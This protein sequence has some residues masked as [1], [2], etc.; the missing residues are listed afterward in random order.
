MLKG[1]SGKKLDIPPFL[2]PRQGVVIYDADGSITACN[3][4]AQEILGLTLAKLQDSSA[5]FLWQTI[6]SDGMLLRPEVSPAMETLRTGESYQ[7]VLT[8]FYRS[9]GEVTWLSVDTEPWLNA[10]VGSPRSV[11]ATFREVPAPQ[12]ALPARTPLSDLTIKSAFQAILQNTSNIIFFKDIQGR[13]VTLSQTAADFLGMGVSEAI[14]KTDHDL[15]CADVLQKIQQD[16]A[17]VMKTGESVAFEEQILYAG[18]VRTLLT[19]KIPWRDQSGHLC[20][21]LGLCR[22]ITDLKQAEQEDRQSRQRL[23]KVLDSLHSIVGLLTPEGVLVEVSQLAL[24]AATLEADEVIGKP[25]P[26]AYWWSYSPEIQAQLWAAVHQAASG[27]MVRYDVL[28]RLSEAQF[29]TIDFSI[30]PLLNESREVEYLVL[31]GLDITYRQETEKTL[32]QNQDVIQSQLSEIESIYQTAPI[33]MAVLDTELRFV[34]INQ[35]LA[36]IN[37]LSVE[38]HI[39]RS[40][41]ELLPALADEAEPQLRQILQT[42]KPVLN[43]EISGET[44]AQPDTQRTWVESWYPQ[45]GQDAQPVGIHIVCEEITERRQ[46]DLA[47]R[48]SETRFRLLTELLPQI[49][50]TATAQG[51]IDYYSEQWREYVGSALKSELGWELHHFIHPEDQA[52][53]AAQWLRSVEEGRFYQIEHRI[54]RVDGEYR[55]YLS[56]AMPNLSDSGEVLKWYGT[57]IDIHERKQTLEALDWALSREKLARAESERANRTKDEFLAVLSH[58]LRSPLNPILGWA[59]LLQTRKLSEEK[60]V[61]ALETIERNAKLQTQLIDDLLDVAKILRGKLKFDPKPVSLDAVVRAAM[62]TVKTAAMAKSISLHLNVVEPV[63]VLGDGTRLQQIVWNLLSN[64]VKFTPSQGRVEIC[65]SQVENY[66]AITVSDTGTGIKAEFLPHLFESFQQEDVTITRSYGGLGLGLSIVHDLVDIHGGTI[67][68][69]SPG[70]GLGATFTVKLPLSDD[71][72][73]AQVLIEPKKELDLTGVQVLYVDDDADSR[74]IVRAVLSAYGATLK[75][76][77]GATEAIS[78]LETYHPDV[79]VLDIGMPE[80]D[81]Y[82][83]LKQIRALPSGRY[84]QTPAISL[85]AY[86]RDEDR[87]AALSRGFQVHATKPIDIDKVAQAVAALARP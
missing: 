19:T 9:N 16:D 66:A 24:E 57:S 4:V 56:R 70:E 50:W 79:L 14:G 59:R 81:G 31:S 15:F 78:L 54:R 18:Q 12:S 67:L 7:A 75:V 17:Q 26:D 21:I 74:E 55:W 45:L 20:G 85:T 22:D 53:S 6:H 77:A 49:F 61:R 38:S 48:E 80:V 62:E 87:E 63:V 1:H 46:R 23:T 42:G 11:M 25:F 83:L 39:G 71:V 10:E 28:V 86:A 65:L 60:T 52:E 35:K 36:E 13:Y 64:A 5:N 69:A 29:V 44:P 47:L 8:G 33:G 82:T 73:T 40:V 76:T 2:S 58:E 30:R 84:R 68:A 27:E 34:R 72:D 32:R 37:G 41:R 43:I 51:E 3:A